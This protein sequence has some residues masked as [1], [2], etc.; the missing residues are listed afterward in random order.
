MP[1]IPCAV[2]EHFHGAIENVLIQ[3][4]ILEKRAE[5]LHRFAGQI[6]TIYLDPPFCT[7]KNFVHKQRCGEIGWL[8]GEPTVS[9]PAYSD[10]WKDIADYIG[11]LREVVM[12]C[13]GLLRD[14]GSL[15]LHI[16]AR[17][18]AQMRLLLDEVF[19]QRHFVNEIIWSYQSGGRATSHFSRKH[20]VI[21]FYRKSKSVY[22]DIKAV[23]VKRANIRNNHMKRDVDEQGRAYRSIVSLGKEYRYYDDDLAYPGD[24]WNDISHLQ[25]KDPQRSGYDNQKPLKLLERIIRCSSRPGDIVCDLF[26]GSGTTGVAA[27]LHGRR[28]LLM[29]ASPVAVAVARSRLLGNALRVE[30]PPVEGKPEI[31]IGFSSEIGVITMILQSYRIEENHCRMPLDGI[32][33]V[34]QLSAGYLRGSVFYAYESVARSRAEPKLRN[35]LTIPML[36]GVP[37][38]LTVDV[39]GRK[40]V[41]VLEEETYDGKI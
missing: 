7:G 1:H 38:M 23:G 40:F 3:G 29:D 26:A 28:F 19:G 21:L 20:D 14:D 30:A 16:D 17:V 4:D 12:L 34:D 31:S 2:E 32:E 25:Q 13:H 18:N 24:V 15:F 35:K 41:H 33:A 39:L 9:L 10:Q 8:T 5:L 22:F 6:Q 36:E 11:L 27:C 37:A